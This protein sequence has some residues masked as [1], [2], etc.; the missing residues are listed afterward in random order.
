MATR[1]SDGKRVKIGTCESMYYCRW[2]QR[3]EVDYPYMTTGLH[4]RL[5]LSKE[6]SIK[7]G[8]FEHYNVLEWSDMCRSHFVPWEAM[9]DEY[10]MS[11][12]NRKELAEHTG[13]VQT[14]VEAL[15]M[16]VNV[17]CH[18][19]LV[20][21]ESVEG[22]VKFFWNGKRDAL[23]FDGV[24][25]KEK[26]LMVGMACS[27]CGKSWSMS[28]QN[29]EPLFKSLRMKLR[30]LHDCS[31]YWHEHNEGECPYTAFSEDKQHRILKLR[32]LA[33]GC[34]AVYADGE[35]VCAGTWD[36]ALHNFVNL[37][38]GYDDRKDATAKER[39]WNEKWNTL[40]HEGEELKKDLL[41][42]A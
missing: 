5:P 13:I 27:A 25:N 16:L 38:P 6:D 32:S 17:T 3:N 40:C 2:D 8:D 28:Y 24:W 30:L 37:L 12:E 10:A 34:Y 14:K 22:S 1:L 31:D 19:G 42:A 39:E 7:P 36:Q 18:H 29:A 41:I 35:E 26:E 15:G 11:S 21:N 33:V 20:L 23:Y 9:V 4:W